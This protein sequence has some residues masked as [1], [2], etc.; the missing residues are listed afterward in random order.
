MILKAIIALLSLLLVTACSTTIYTSTTQITDN[1]EAQTAFQHG[2]QAG[3]QNRHEEALR[4]F[5]LTLQ[6]APD[7]SE[8]YR[9]A[10][11]ALTNLG[12]AKESI[13]YFEKAILLNPNSAEAYINLATALGRVNRAE[14]GL[15]AYLRAS[16]INPTLAK[17]W[18]RVEKGLSLQYETYMPTTEMD[19]PYQMFGLR[20]KPP[21][22]D[23]WQV[24]R[25]SNP[26]EVTFARSTERGSEH[27]IRAF[28]ATFF[29]SDLNTPDSQ[30]LSKA[31]RWSLDQFKVSRYDNLDFIIHDLQK[32]GATC[33][34]YSFKVI[35]RGVP[36]A[37]G[38]TFY[39]HGVVTFCVHPSSPFL[40]ELSYSQ[41]HLKRWQPIPLEAE[42]KPFLAEL[43]M[44]R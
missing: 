22:G 9:N 17:K 4:Q 42:L 3:N 2:V 10:G 41:R 26:S 25:E 19:N 35:D 31:V 8:G 1:P 11:L 44:T 33:R 16:E 6:H 15:E 36:Y 13:R 18:S 5:E 38:K 21:K 37:P 20:I 7:L 23:L 30:W 27:T 43:E 40:I 24:A 29:L 34:Q 12:R 32:Y 28:A 14:E 39:L